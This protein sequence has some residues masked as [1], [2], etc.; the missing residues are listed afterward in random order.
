MLGFLTALVGRRGIWICT[1]SVEAAV[2]RH[3]EDQLF[4]FRDKDAELYAQIKAIQIEEE[5]HL[6]HALERIAGTTPWT[7]LLTTIISTSTD[8][9]IWL[10]T[11]GDSAN[12]ARDLRAAKTMLQGPNSARP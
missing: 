3:L 7:R 11:W 12:M 1:V 5:S 10:S 8:A 4:F 9:L 6:N 2:Q